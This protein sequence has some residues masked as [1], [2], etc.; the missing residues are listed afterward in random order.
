MAAGVRTAF[1]GT[2]VDRVNAA[3]MEPDRGGR[4]QGSRI[5]GPVSCKNTALRERWSFDE[6]RESVPGVLDGGIMGLTYVR[7][8]PWV[9]GMT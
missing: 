4:S 1:D 7:A 6:V 2:F 5:M 8:V 9:G 3:S